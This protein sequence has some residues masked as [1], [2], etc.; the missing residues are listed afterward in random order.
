[1]KLLRLIIESE[2]GFRSLRKGFEVRFHH[3]NNWKKL[4]E[5][6]PF[7]LVGLNGCGKSN[8]MEALAH[9]FY[10]IELCISQH[11]PDYVLDER[12]FSPKKCVVDAFTLEYL[13]VQKQDHSHLKDLTRK[14]IIT[15]RTNE[16]ARLTFVFPNSEHQHAVTIDLDGIE[17][18]GMS[19]FIRGFL[20]QYIV[21]YSSGE[22]ETLSIPFIKS[23]LL[24]LDE[25]KQATVGDYK[26]YVNPENNLIYIDANMSQAILLCCLLFEDDATLEPL[27]AYDNT[28]ILKI[29]RFRMCLKRKTFLFDKKKYSFLSLLERDWFPKFQSCS[30]MSWYDDLNEVYYFDFFVNE[31]TKQAFR[32]HFH[33]SMECFQMFRLLYELNYHSVENSKVREVIAST[34]MYTEGKIDNPGADNDVF[35]FLDFYLEKQIDKDG[36][37]K[38]MLLRQLSDGEHQFIHT[39]AICLLL[40]ENDS[41][42]LLDEPETHFNPSWRSRFVSI[43]DDTLKAAYESDYI[44]TNV[45]NLAKEILITSHSPFIISDCLSDNVIIMDKD[46]KDKV[47]AK[48]ASE[49][50]IKTYGTSIGLLMS[51]IFGNNASIGKLS[52]NAILKVVDEG[53]TKEE[54]KKRLNECFGDSVE[55]LLAIESLE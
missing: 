24:H 28:G 10:H 42:L 8:V 1:M 27:K 12:V 9:I 38:E 51:Q 18:G 6:H 55:K 45:A 37:S 40:K 4:T 43:L 15:K 14:V 23:R 36:N 7:C 49:L 25:F 17:R 52:E 54:I 30:T 21:A 11:L 26:D 46:V 22:N 39:M 32:I 41:L 13:I 35:H 53:R 5:F 20:P 31:A 47:Y 3:P 29:N 34:G 44:D 2:E 16:T 19:Y 50:G 48:H 33:S